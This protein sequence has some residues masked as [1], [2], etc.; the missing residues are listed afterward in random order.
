MKCIIRFEFNI[1]NVLAKRHDV[2]AT[3]LLFGNR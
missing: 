3:L 1:I 2:A